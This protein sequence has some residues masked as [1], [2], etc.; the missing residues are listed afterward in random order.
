MANFKISWFNQIFKETHT[1]IF[2]YIVEK[3]N[4]IIII[5]LFV[6]FQVTIKQKQLFL[7]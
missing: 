6:Y 2:L 1:I 3:Y 4:P 5:F 7:L